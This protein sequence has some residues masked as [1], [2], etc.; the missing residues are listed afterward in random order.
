MAEDEAQPEAHD[1]AS[2]LL[3]IPLD[4]LRPEAFGLTS[5]QRGIRR[6]LDGAT[7]PAP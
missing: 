5:I 7:S 3:W 6:F 1:D 2:E 4:A